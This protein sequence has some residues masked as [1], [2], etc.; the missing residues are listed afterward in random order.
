MAASL[1]NLQA[2]PMGSNDH[3]VGRKRSYE[4]ATKVNIP[5]I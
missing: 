1:N 3:E 2:N 5:E 4:V